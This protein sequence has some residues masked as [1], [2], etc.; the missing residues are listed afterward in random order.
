MPR[1]HVL[2][3]HTCLP[4]TGSGFPAV[5]VGKSAMVEQAVQTGSVDSLTAKKLLP[6]KGTSAAQLSGRPAQPSS[7]PTAGTAH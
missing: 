2:P 6:V 7:K 3:F 5:P 4:R 1:C